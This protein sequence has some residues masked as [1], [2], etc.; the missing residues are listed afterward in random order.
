MASE[1][2][3]NKRKLIDRLVPDEKWGPLLGVLATSYEM[4]PEFLETDLMPAILGLGS[5]DSHGWTSRIAMEK[6]LAQTRT[7]TVLM[8]ASRYQGRP[9]SMRIQIVPVDLG[10]GGV[11]HAKVLLLLFQDAV[12]LVIG[13]AN[14]TEQ[15]YRRTRRR[16]TPRGS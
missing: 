6:R 8:D 7:A 10:T 16:V 12:R 2:D 9:R 13:S 14:L 11:L 15:G 4:R 1:S 3:V 5:W